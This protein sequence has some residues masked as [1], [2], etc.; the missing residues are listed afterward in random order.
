VLRRTLIFRGRRPTDSRR[1]EKQAMNHKSTPMTPRAA[2][3]IQS[4][5]DRSG[6]NA[7]FKARAQGAAVRN[8]PGAAPPAA[9]TSTPTD[10]GGQK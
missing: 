5:A 2:A 7:G 9:P 4:H 3:R 1:K 6:K 10:A 8:A